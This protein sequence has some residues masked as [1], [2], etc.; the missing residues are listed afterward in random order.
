MHFISF[1]LFKYKNHYNHRSEYSVAGGIIVQNIR[2]AES[3]WLLFTFQLEHRGPNTRLIIII[4]IIMIIIKKKRNCI[5]PR[6]TIRW[7]STTLSKFALLSSNPLPQATPSHHPRSPHSQNRNSHR[8]RRPVQCLFILP[9]LDRATITR[10][11]IDRTARSFDVTMTTPEI[12]IKRICARRNRSWRALPPC[13]PWPT[14]LSDRSS[15][16][17][18]VDRDSR[19]LPSEPNVEKRWDFRWLKGRK[20]APVGADCLFAR[21]IH[22]GDTFFSLRDRETPLVEITENPEQC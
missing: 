18:R 13:L 4:I 7:I 10:N 9:L 20:E 14:D 22:A 5:R 11:S 16:A 8:S 15:P 19:T 2:G 21:I 3:V 17:T 12:T 1:S 6:L